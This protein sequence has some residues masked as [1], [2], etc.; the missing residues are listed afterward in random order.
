LTGATHHAQARMDALEDLLAFAGNY[1]A[2]QG[3]GNDDALRLTLVLEELFTNTVTHGHR[4]DC[5]APLRVA[6]SCTASH[7]L[8]LYEDSAPPFDPLSG[9]DEAARQV[10]LPAEQRRD[11]GLGM[12]LVAQWASSMRYAHDEGRNRLWVELPRRD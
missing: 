9:L 8:L 6:L 4:G 10:D 5:D 11:G 12:L 1:C 7:L 2:A 3:V